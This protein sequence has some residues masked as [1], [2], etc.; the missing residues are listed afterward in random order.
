MAA[1]QNYTLPVSASNQAV[2]Q[3]WQELFAFHAAMP[4]S[5]V[6]VCSALVAVEH[7]APAHTHNLPAYIT[8]TRRYFCRTQIVCMK[9]TAMPSRLAA[10]AA[11]TES[12]P[13]PDI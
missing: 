8:A 7:P 12:G 3:G 13:A 11:N 2:A 4:A 1:G 5:T 9:I 10:H 6:P